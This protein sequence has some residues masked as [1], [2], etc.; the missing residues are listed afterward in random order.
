MSTSS[1]QPAAKR[2]ALPA[3]PD[4][5]HNILLAAEKLFA[6]F[7][8]HAVSI[9]DIADEAQVPLALV[10]YY[11]GQKHELYHAIFEHWNSTI[12][13]R[14]ASLREALTEKSSD[15]LARIVEAFVLPV[16][17]LRASP[18]GEYYALLMT[19]GLSLQSEDEDRII[20]EFFDP[21][22]R[23]FIDAFHATLAVEFPKVTHAQVCWCYQFALGSLVHHISDTR[24]QRLSQDKNRP[25]DPAVTP[26]L[27]AFITA[28]MRGAAG[29][30]HPPARHR[31]TG[32]HAKGKRT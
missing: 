1:R 28:G 22:A 3:K 21:M 15:R 10:G 32:A 19:R 2:P 13:E 26:Q 7:G 11:F 12:N 27:V 14:L 24:V 17:R 25:C 29:T 5:K 4:R 18:E 9:R 6:N 23:A 16:F 8:Y 30:W 31:G 20:R